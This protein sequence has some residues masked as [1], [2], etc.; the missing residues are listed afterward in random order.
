MPLYG[1]YPSDPRVR[2]EVTEL[3][4]LDLD[5][6]IVCL[7]QD[8]GELPP[9]VHV[10]SLM[11]NVRSN[12][13]E[14]IPNLIFF[15]VFCFIFLTKQDKGL[16]IHAHDLTALPPAAL[17]KFFHICSILIYDSHE[18]FP[19]AA[20]T[21]LGWIFGFF[22]FTLEKL[23]VLFVDLL[24]GIS[25]FQ[26][27]LFFS[28]Y[29]K[30]MIV[31][32][33]YPT[34]KEVDKLSSLSPLKY[35]TD[36]FVITAHGTVRQDRCYFELLTA[37][38]M[39]YDNG[40][41]IHLLN[42]GDGPDKQAVDEY[43]TTNHLTNVHSIGKLPFSDTFRYLMGSNGAIGLGEY[44]IP[45]MYGSSNKLY[46]FI[47]A[48]IPAAYS[49]HPNSRGP[50]GKAHFISISNNHPKTIYKSILK[51]KQSD[52]TLYKNNRSLIEDYYNWEQ[53]CH[54]LVQ[55]YDQIFHVS[56]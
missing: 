13:R 22:F 3:L 16:I 44:S 36:G 34:L 19:D 46:E 40:L 56:S 15:W 45:N 51:L 35:N 23:C 2:K 21:E 42:N 6:H 41:N 37:F 39:I 38:K 52:P 31:L 9:N 5:I 7:N 11:K 17:A 30:H 53:S 49:D 1:Y 27:D 12:Q 25:T 29:H 47:A 8:Q 55:L 32:P 10:H 20:K 33:N 43:I 50:I 48:N 28:R 4:S 54:K 14:S 24:V 18:F 26:R